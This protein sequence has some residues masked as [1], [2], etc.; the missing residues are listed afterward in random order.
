MRIETEDNPP[1]NPPTDNFYDSDGHPLLFHEF[2]NGSRRSK[3][4]GGRMVF[5]GG[6]ERKLSKSQFEKV[7]RMLFWF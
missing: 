2:T 1:R 6:E 7:R 5:P 3:G 4:K